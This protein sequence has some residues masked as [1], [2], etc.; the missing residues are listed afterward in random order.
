MKCNVGKIDRIIRTLIAVVLLII[1]FI[2]RDS[3]GAWQFVLYVLAIILLSTVVTKFCLPYTWLK[4]S[5]C[6]KESVKSVKNKKR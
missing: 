6:D 4:I 5:T 3:I 2:N 1:G